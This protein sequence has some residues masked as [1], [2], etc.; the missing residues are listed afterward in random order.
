MDFRSIFAI[1]HKEIL[2]ILRDKRTLFVA[3]AMPVMMLLLYGYAI[4]MDLKNITVGIYDQDQSNHSRKLL[5]R[6]LAN[7][8]FI[9]TAH[10]T[11]YNQIEQGFRTQTFRVAIIIPHQFANSLAQKKQTPIQV[12]IDGS[13]A[14]SANIIMNSISASIQSFSLEFFQTQLN[15]PNIPLI[16]IQSR[17]WFN[18]ELKSPIFIVPGL[19]A[20]FLVMVCALLTSVALAKE[21]ELGTLEQLLTTPIKAQEMM[22]GKLLPYTLIASIDA[23]LVLLIGRYLFQV[24]L[25]GSV[26][27][28]VVY[29]AI[30]LLVALG[31]GLMISVLVKTQQLALMSALV[32]TLLPTLLLSGLIFPISSM[33]K[34]LQVISYIIPARWYIEIVRGVMLKGINWF[35]KNAFIL[36]SMAILLITMSTRK[37]HQQ[38]KKGEL[39]T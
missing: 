27:A 35:P 7:Q 32:A 19:I 2:H 1:S 16:N 38:L 36:F 26:F 10:L 3:V 22:I 11:H 12:I 30:Y 4:D 39:T 25:K 31:M 24:P 34:A 29:S 9:Q 15:T 20:L 37:F 28:L 21:K 8:T 17:I 13:D 33:P 23:T 5:E 6:V 14:N 18:E